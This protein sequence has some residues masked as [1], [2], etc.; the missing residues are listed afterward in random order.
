MGELTNEWALPSINLDACQK[1][2]TCVEKCPTMAVEMGLDGPS[3]ARP[4][5]CTYCADCEAICPQGAITCPFEIVW[6]NPKTT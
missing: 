5:D 2:G 4:Q 6:A 1:C 3:I